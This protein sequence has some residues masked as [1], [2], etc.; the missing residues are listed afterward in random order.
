MKITKFLASTALAAALCSAPAFA[1]DED[2]ATLFLNGLND[3][4]EAQGSSLRVYS[5]EILGSGK[6]VEMGRTVIASNH[7]NKQ[8]GHD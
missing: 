8:L 1:Q 3:T 5:A 2:G 7:G 6:G 4:L